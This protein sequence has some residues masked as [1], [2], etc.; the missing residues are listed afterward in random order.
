MKV[1]MRNLLNNNIVFIGLIF[2][3]GAG[4]RKDP[5][6]IDEKPSSSGCVEAWCD[7][8]P[9]P[10]EIGFAYTTEGY[11]YLAPCFNPNNSNE[12]VY[13]RWNGTN[14]AEL[15]KYDLITNTESVLLDPMSLGRPDWGR[16]GWITFVYNYV[17]VWKIYDDGSQLTQL[18]SGEDDKY[19]AFN[20]SGDEIYY[21]R[22]KW[23]SN[24]EL[25]ANP[26]LYKNSKMLIIDLNGNIVDS[27]I[28]PN[29]YNQYETSFTYQ[30]WSEAATDVN[31]YWCFAAGND[32]RYGL[33]SLQNDTILKLKEWFYPQDF[34]DIEIYG[35][36]LYYSK[37]QKGLFK[38][39]AN[40]GQETKLKWGCDT[41]HYKYLSVSSDGQKILVQKV[42]SKPYNDNKSIDEQ[43]EIWLLDV[44]GCGEQKILGD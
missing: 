10:P 21:L 35:T 4:C 26:E 43:N 24:A 32:Y 40:T 20:Y 36:T 14:H 19:P 39:D 12:F 7:E 28:E 22:K 33:Y 37:Y 8:F 38:L 3:S 42:I 18:T 23:Y 27:I 16:Q 2:F 44:N 34:V 25:D 29:I 11:Q 15:F 5:H 1:I 13:I 30:T 9:E 41:R 31:N 17:N 6:L